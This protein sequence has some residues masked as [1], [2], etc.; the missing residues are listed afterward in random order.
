[1]S[2]ATQPGAADIVGEPAPILVEQ[3]GLARW[4]RLNRPSTRNALTPS[5]VAALN[6]ALHEAEADDETDIVVIA[7]EGPSFCSG[8]DL[9]YLRELAQLDRDPRSFL[10]DVSDC[11]SR[12]ESAAKPIVA[13]V[14][15]HV[16]AG[17]LEL[18]LA[19]DVVIAQN[20]TMLGDGHLRNGLLPGGGASLRLPRKLGEP[21]ARWLMLT[22]ESLP[23]EA[24]LS[25]GFVHTVVT[26]E[27]FHEAVTSVVERLATTPPKARARVKRLLRHWP[28][29]PTE[30]ATARELDIF[31]E[32]W[33]EFDVIS[34]LTAFIDRKVKD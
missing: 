3:E 8:A 26:T 2:V 16:V 28:E 22:G 29:L 24:F 31:T 4:L 15:G 20:G 9:R 34:G 30:T 27:S 23:A 12:I 33:Q 6:T 11:F 19:C 13:A 5:L 25:C 14:H 21:L 18:A 1:M 32:H 7:G 10:A 17:G